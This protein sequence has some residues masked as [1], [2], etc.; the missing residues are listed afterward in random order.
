MASELQE[1]PL[2]RFQIRPRQLW[3][4]LWSLESLFSGDYDEYLDCGP[5]IGDP[6]YEPL[7]TVHV[8]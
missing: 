1:S 5:G 7:R 6:F 4:T 3:D 2:F 8:H